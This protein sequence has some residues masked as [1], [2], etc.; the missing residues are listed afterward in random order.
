MTQL[1]AEGTVETPPASRFAA[2]LAAPGLSAL[3]SF[4][5]PRTALPGAAPLRLVPAALTP[6]RLLPALRS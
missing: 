1:F 6:S 2:S 4:F 3:R 5:T